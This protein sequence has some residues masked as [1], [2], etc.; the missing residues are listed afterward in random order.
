MLASSYVKLNDSAGYTFVLEKELV[1][2]PKKEYWTEAIRRVDGR[3]GFPEYLQLDVLRL[4]EA[5]GSLTTATQYTTMAQLALKA[6]WPGEAKRI[7]DAGFAAGMLGVGADADM[8]RKLRDAATKQVADDEKVLAQN[9]RDAGAAKDGTALVTVGYAMVTAG[10]IAKGLELMEQGIQKGG[11]SRPED[12]RLHLA[13]A[14]LAA[15]RK[16][17]AI[18]TFKAVQ[19]SDA[20]ADI[21]RLWLIHVQRSSG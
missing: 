14:Y 5:T 18:E 11:M 7:M 16:A 1:Y 21:A 19:G 10:Q 2:Y 20:T 8:Q 15:G 12:A 9:A 13:I 17:K 6:G 3:P 4:Y